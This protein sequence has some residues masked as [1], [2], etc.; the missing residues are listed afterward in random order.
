MRHLGMQ[1]VLGV[2]IKNASSGNFVT[3]NLTSQ[4]TYDITCTGPNWMDL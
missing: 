3:A 1:V 2:G 4:M